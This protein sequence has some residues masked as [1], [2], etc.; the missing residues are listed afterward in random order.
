[1]R[2]G[3]PTGSAFFLPPGLGT[4][5]R[6]EL[7]GEAHLGWNVGEAA[8]H[9]LQDCLSLFQHE[10]LALDRSEKHIPGGEAQLPAEIRR[11]DQSSLRS[12][13]HFGRMDE[14]FHGLLILP[15]RARACLVRSR[16]ASPGGQQNGLSVAEATAIATSLSGEYGRQLFRE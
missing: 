12:H 16:P 11:D 15:H 9:S 2:L 4:S 8:P 3:V 10:P 6:D 5:L 7:L 1:M 13:S 14:S